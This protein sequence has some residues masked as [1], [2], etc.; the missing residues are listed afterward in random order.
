[1]TSQREGYLSW[2]SRIYAAQRIEQLGWPN[3][4]LDIKEI[5]E[6]VGFAMKFLSKSLINKNYKNLASVLTNGNKSLAFARLKEEFNSLNAE[7]K[8]L[9]ELSKMAENVH[10]VA[11]RFDIAQDFTDTELPITFLSLKCWCVI[12]IAK[13]PSYLVNCLKI[14]KIG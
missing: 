10:V 14:Y 2:K 13:C 12:N 4:K 9:V 3:P 1:M 8:K 6:G 7:D 11:T 5:K